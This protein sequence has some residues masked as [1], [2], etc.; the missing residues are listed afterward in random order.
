MRWFNAQHIGMELKQIELNRKAKEQEFVD[1][2]A[3]KALVAFMANPAQWQ[4]PEQLASW[5][6]QIAREMLKAREAQP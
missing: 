2:I 5:S 6:Y 3:A 1:E 4:T